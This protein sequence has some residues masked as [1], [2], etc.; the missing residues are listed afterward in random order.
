MSLKV[1]LSLFY[2]IL[3]ISFK[4]FLRVTRV[5]NMQALPIYGCVIHMYLYVCICMFVC[6]CLH[7]CVHIYMYVD[8]WRFVY[9]F[10]LFIDIE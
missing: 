7:L 10:L 2:Y 3:S 4:K 6:V 9:V 5:A 8:T 1:L